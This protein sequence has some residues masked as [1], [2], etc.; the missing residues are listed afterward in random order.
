M[1]Y[2]PQQTASY[3]ALQGSSPSLQAANNSG[4]KVQPASTS[5]AQILQ[6][7][8]APAYNQTLVSGTKGSGLAPTGIIPAGPAPDPNAA[9]NAAAAAKAAA[10]AAAA[11]NLRTQVTQLVNGIKDIF[12]SRYGQIDAQAGEQIGKLNDRFGTESQDIT[13]Q[14]TGENNTISAQHAGRGTFDSSYR[15]NNVDTVTHAGEAQVRDLGTELQD[16]ISKVGQYVAS[17]K[18]GYD[19]QKGGVDAILTHLAEETDPGRLTDLRNTLDSRIAELK[20]GGADNNTAA[21]NASALASIAPS[22]ARTVQLQT[23]LSQILQGNADSS[24]KSTIGQKLIQS[25]GLSPAEAQKLTQAFSSDL[26]ATDPQK[27]QA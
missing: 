27:Q 20:A 24:L 19:A 12:N 14:V 6:P 25:A 10:D 18:T 1:P 17:Q 8:V 15:G 22:S 2:N 5:S 9:A 21:Q 26:S 7:T 16:N 23:T 4:L 13:N 11:A 3:T